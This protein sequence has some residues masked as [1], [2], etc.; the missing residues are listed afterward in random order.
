MKILSYKFEDHNKYILYDQQDKIINLR[1][2]YKVFHKKPLT[3]I[4]SYKTGSLVMDTIPLSIPFNESNPLA[5]VDKF[6]KL[7]TIHSKC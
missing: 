6:F 5:S 4:I 3:Q 2:E 7:L 1:F